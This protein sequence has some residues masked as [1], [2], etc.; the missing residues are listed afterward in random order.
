MKIANR[1]KIAIVTHNIIKRDGQGRVNCELVKYLAA[2]GHEVHLYANRVSQDL[3]EL[4]NIIYHYVSILIE[5]PNLIKGI[6][7]LLRVTWRLSKSHYD[8]V[9]LNGTVSLTPYDVNTCHLCHSA[10][11][12]VSDEINQEKGLIKIYYWLY[13]RFNV[14]LERI[15]YHKR[16]G[17]VIAVSK[18]VKTELIS[19]AG[20]LKK[21]IRVIPNGVN[22]EE[23]S[24]KDRS[25][26]KKFVI[27]EF[28]LEKDDFLILFAGDIRINRK[29]LS[30]LLESLKD[31]NSNRVKLLIAGNNRRSPFVKRVEEDRLSEKMKFIG[32]RNDLDKIFK[33]I[34]AFVFPTRHDP[35]GM[36]VLEAMAC[37]VPA[38]V[39]DSR[40]CG[41]SELIKDMENGI[42]LRDP[43][44]SKEIRKKIELLI[45]DRELRK[46]IG[47]NARSTAENYSWAK[48]AEKY[49]K[50]YFEI[51]EDKK[52]LKRQDEN[53]SR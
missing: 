5:K 23:F 33:G 15:I 38:I 30:Y 6:I 45:S 53:P 36:V 42:L 52:K 28:N 49:E 16:K 19:K 31:L 27:R 47:R 35:F 3:L 44:N 13:T 20:V 11:A 26:C 17:L 39:S 14:W 29:G 9:H 51:L 18:K 37:G 46:K 24:E 43:T 4:D 50:V 10:W 21:K 48:M 32:F 7:F 34:E 2:R 25:I 1:L 8:I 40:Y 41:A 12:E 22:T